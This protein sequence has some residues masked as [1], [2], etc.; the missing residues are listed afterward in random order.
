[1]DI[2]ERIDAILKEKR[3]SR[4]KLAQMAGLP[5]STLGNAFMRKSS[6]PMSTVQKL[7]SALDVDINELLGARPSDDLDRALAAFPN[8]TAVEENGQTTIYLINDPKDPRSPQEIIREDMLRR[9]DNMNETGQSKAYSYI[10]DIEPAHP[11]R[12]EE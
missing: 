7:S 2:Y 5:E 8:A 1:M 11:R 4:R 3:I 10:K 9:Y 12:K 6:L